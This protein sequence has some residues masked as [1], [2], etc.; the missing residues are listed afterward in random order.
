MHLAAGL[1]QLDR[2]PAKERRLLARQALVQRGVD[3][4]VDDLAEEVVH[5]L[6]RGAVGFGRAADAGHVARKVGDPFAIFQGWPPAD[7]HLLH[8]L[9]EG[10]D[11]M[12]R[13]D[14]F[15]GQ[16]GGGRPELEIRGDVSVE[17][18]EPRDGRIGWERQPP[19]APRAQAGRTCTL[20]CAAVARQH[21]CRRDGSVRAGR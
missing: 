18:G 4:A 12:L 19:D 1:R 7:P 14:E 6:R 2:R 15:Q 9:L 13:G 10:G 17:P 8:L 21:R 20:L 3:D 5:D 16:A 11:E